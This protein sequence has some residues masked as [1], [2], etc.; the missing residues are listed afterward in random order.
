MPERVCAGEGCRAWLVV[1]SL[2]YLG[3]ERVTPLSLPKGSSLG[4]YS[5]E[6]AAPRCRGGN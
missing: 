4:L 5:A 2:G 6:L 3:R 1:G